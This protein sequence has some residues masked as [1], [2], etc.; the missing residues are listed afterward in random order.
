[1]EISPDTTLETFGLFLALV[2]PGLLAVNVYR[3][4]VPGPKFEWKDSVTQG[5]FYTVVNYMLTF[6]IALFV[7]RTENLSVH[8]FLYW[9]A[10]ALVLLAA[11]V[12]L[13]FGW[14]WLLRRRWISKLVQSPYPTPWDWY[15]SRRQ[16]VFLLIHLADGSL[17]GGYWGE[18]S[19]ASSY[20]DQGDLYVSAAY[21]V[22]EHGRF[23]API[24][25]TDGLLIRK[26][27][28]RYIELFRVP[29]TEV[30]NEQEVATASPSN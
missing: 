15:F 11:P 4:I 8:P 28:Y 23:G 16:P 27:Q 1:M 20:P 2:W 3:L 18:G 30:A 13:P 22:D 12:V 29:I 26:D 25:H 21:K 19:Y 5:V 24:D 9:L 6:P 10:L 17:V 14:I 7:I